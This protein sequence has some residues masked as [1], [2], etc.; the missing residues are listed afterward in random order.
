MHDFDRHH[1][2]CSLPGRWPKPVFDQLQTMIARER[3][4]AIAYL[5]RLDAI[6]VDHYHG[7][8]PFPATRALL[9]LVTQVD[10]HAKI[11][12]MD[13]QPEPSLVVP[14]LHDVQRVE[15]MAFQTT[16]LAEM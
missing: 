3:A 8:R 2:R 10:H 1:R 5:D 13:L 16:L 14:L 11:H 6:L 12:Q 15:L 9:S 7:C 4:L